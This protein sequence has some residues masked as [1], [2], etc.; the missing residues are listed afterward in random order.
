MENTRNNLLRP[1]SPTAEPTN[2]PADVPDSSPSPTPSPTIAMVKD[3]IDGI[4]TF[5]SLGL[6][7]LYISLFTTALWSRTND[8]V[9]LGVCLGISA[10]ICA[11]GAFFYRRANKDS[12]A[13]KLLRYAQ[14]VIKFLA[15]L[16]VSA[17]F[18]SGFVS[19][20][21]SGIVMVATTVGPAVVIYFLIKTIWNSPALNRLSL[22]RLNMNHF[23][24]KKRG[25]RKI[26]SS[27]LFLGKPDGP[28]PS[29]EAATLVR[30]SLIVFYLAFAVHLTFLLG[31]NVF[32]TWLKSFPVDGFVYLILFVAALIVTI[33]YQKKV[34]G[35]FFI[36]VGLSILL[37]VVLSFIPG[38]GLIMILLGSFACL[39]MSI[40]LIFQALKDRWLMPLFLAVASLSLFVSVLDSLRDV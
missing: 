8:F 13:A 18:F 12:R 21:S 23:E 37:T 39:A 9:V 2:A 16:I 11:G 14:E 35:R 31:V 10:L 38:L 34:I 3:I 1:N 20:S 40:T 33:Y 19:S 6:L 32:E 26:T 25:E 17:Q 24:L 29:G 4:V 7:L 28:P 5:A 15:L 30:F 27:G 22:R 36:T